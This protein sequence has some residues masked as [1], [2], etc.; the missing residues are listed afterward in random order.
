MRAYVLAVLAAGALMLVVTAELPDFGDI[1][2]AFL[3][4]G[5]AAVGLLRPMYLSQKLKVT[6]EDV[7]TFAAA[8]VL[9][10]FF[11][12]VVAG[13][14]TLLALRTSPGEPWG[15]RA[16]NAAVAA[17]GTIAAALMF[18]WLAG[19]GAIADNLVAVA[20]AGVTKYGLETS[21][22]D[23]AVGLQLRRNPLPTWW[24]I[25]RRDLVPHAGLYLVGVLAAVMAAATPWAILAFIVPAAGLSVL[26]QERVRLGDRSQRAILELADRVDARDPY[27]RG[28]SQR[29][30]VIA[31]RL[32]L[33]MGLDSSQ[34]EL[35]RLAARVHDIGKIATNDEV[36]LK[37]G[38]LDPLE[39][40]EM[41][42]HSELGAILLGQIPEFWEGAS[43]V[44]AHHER[45]D[46][47]GYPRGLRGDELSLEA[48]VVAVADAYD[49]MT[50][51]R[52][53]RKGMPWHQAR[54]QLVQHGGTQWDARVVGALLDLIDEDQ[55]RIEVALDRG[56]RAS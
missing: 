23:V 50:S 12:G 37:R 33:R 16:F 18:G 45:P 26:L 19:G 34:V 6:A 39:S 42:R 11:A 46:G 28:H 20:A 55:R 31:E 44:L 21:L 25:H 22:V 54:A 36:L 24:R 32:A 17:I 38:P 2:R 56:A 40:R 7:A 10:P 3:F 52:P 5:V 53:Y 41:H 13:T 35:I 49:A 4:A 43:I 29:T 48:A 27:T 51:D 30:A 8:L 1:A 14:S 15:L 47:A 9:A